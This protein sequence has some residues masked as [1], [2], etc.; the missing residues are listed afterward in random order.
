MIMVFDRSPFDE[1]NPRFFLLPSIQFLEAIRPH[2]E[3]VAGGFATDPDN[4]GATQARI[5]RALSKR[6]R[7][8]FPDET[9]LEE[10]LKY[11]REATRGPDGRVI[12]IY[13][14]PIGLQ[15]AEKSMTSTVKGMDL[16][17]VK[18]E[19]SLRLCLRQLELSYVIRDGLLLITS[20]EDAE[21]LINWPN[22]DAFQIVGHC[23]LAL[24][25]AALGGAAAPWVCDL[26]AP[27]ARATSPASPPPRDGDKNEPMPPRSRLRAS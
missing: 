18:L 2:F 11:I 10:I 3:T 24:I 25:A 8:R 23:L 27:T 12:P 13:V 21:T 1:H 22:D 7:M 20:Q 15:E 5:Q 26:A 14:D 17:G 9:T 6:V 19:T 4:V 16:E